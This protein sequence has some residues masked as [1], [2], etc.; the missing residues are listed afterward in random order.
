MTVA[1]SEVLDVTRNRAQSVSARDRVARWRKYPESLV[2]KNLPTSSRHKANKKQKMVTLSFYFI[3][4]T[5][6]KL[7]TIQ[8]D[9]ITIG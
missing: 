1:A 8:H 2:D 7:H 3:E 5:Y 4:Y 9:M 6:S